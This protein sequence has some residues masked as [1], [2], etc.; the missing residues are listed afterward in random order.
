MLRV[1]GRRGAP[2]ACL[3][4]AVHGR[5]GVGQQ[6]AFAVRVIGEQRHTDTGTDLQL[7]ALILEWQLQSAVYPVRNR[8][9]IRGLADFRQYDG[10]FIAADARYGVHFADRRFEPRRDFP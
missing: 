4:D 1:I 9:Y 8:G 6:L 3:F 5:V 7:S 2:A 10:E